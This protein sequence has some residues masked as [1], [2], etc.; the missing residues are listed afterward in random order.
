MTSC[1]VPFMKRLTGSVAIT[2]G[3][4]L[5]SSVVSVVLMASLSSTVI[6]RRLDPELVD[7]PVGERR[8]ERVVD[9][10]VLLDER[11]TVE[12]GALDRSPGSGRRR[13]CDPRPRASP[14][15]GRLWRRSVSSVLGAGHGSIVAALVGFAP[16]STRYERRVTLRDV[17]LLALVRG[18]RSARPRPQRSARRG[19]RLRAGDDL[20]PLPSL[21]RAPGHSPL[22]LEHDRGRSRRRQSNSRSRTGRHRARLIRTHPAI[23]AHA[24]ATCGALLPGPLLPRARDRREPER[25]RPRRPLARAGRAARAARGGDRGDPAP[26]AGRRADAPRHALHGRPRAALHASRGADSDRGGRGASRSRPS[27]PAGRRRARQR[28]SGP[29]D[30]EAVPRGRRRRAR[31][32][33]RSSSAGR[34]T[35]TRRSRRSSSS[36]GTA[37]SRGTLNQ[38]LPRPSDFDAVA[39]SVTVEMATEGVPCGPDP[40]PVLALVARVGGGRLRP[41]LLHQVG[42]DQ[43]GF[44]RFWEDELRPKLG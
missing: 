22:R 23:V 42:S 36:G 4:G 43:E 44:F 35:R 37:G 9:Q 11:E 15:R 25:A 32:T 28:R 20:G 14:R 8:G 33:A 19:G 17:R 26:L 3:S 29:G 27:S 12:A 6:R 40:E 41:D 7:R 38:E 5:R 18:A 1:G 34:R 21:E 39:E 31:A 16:G 24:A 2:P 30:R 13:R 10:A